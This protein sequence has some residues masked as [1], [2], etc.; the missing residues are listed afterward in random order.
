MKKLKVPAWAYALLLVA[1]T[2][3]AL[4]M[5]DANS[6]SSSL[7]SYAWR[8]VNF[9]CGI[10]AICIVGDIAWHARDMMQHGQRVK[11][12]FTSLAILACLYGIMAFILGAGDAQGTTVSG[13]DTAMSMKP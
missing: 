12:G 6:A 13:L 7:Y 3:P 4:A 11:L 10:S 1:L 2:M 9:L 5:A 8:I